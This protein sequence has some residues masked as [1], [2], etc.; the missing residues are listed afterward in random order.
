MFV[1][2]IIS[3]L[4]G[5]FTL[6]L[7]SAAMLRAVYSNKQLTLMRWVMVAKARQPLP[8]MR[9]AKSLEARLAN[10]EAAASLSSRLTWSLRQL[11]KF[12][13]GIHSLSSLVCFEL[14]DSTLTSPS[15]APGCPPR[16]GCPGRT[17]RPRRRSG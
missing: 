2:L 16:C 12:L 5:L 3:Q 4:L 11:L 8:P 14:I 6:Q 17:S 15:P 7:I 1:N 13:Y 10:L 9:M